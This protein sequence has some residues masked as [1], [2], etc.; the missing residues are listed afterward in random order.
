MN[1]LTEPTIDVYA[2]G[3]DSRDL[4]LPGL[5]AGLSCG[6][7]DGFPSLQPHQRH[8]WHAFLV[9]LAAIAL[10]AAGRCDPP[11]EEDAWR[12][13]LRAIASGPE[14][15]P[16]R[17]VVDDLAR[18]AFMQP[19]VPEGTLEGFG[20]PLS[21][22]SDLDVLVTSMNH[23]V[24][25]RR[26]VNARPAHWVYAL[27]TLQTMQGYSGAGKHGI[28]R[29]NGVFA[30]RPCVG[31]AP[32]DRCAE[33][34]CRDVAVLL[35]A[36]SEL[37]RAYAPAFRESGGVS[38]L[39]LEAWNGIEALTMETLDPYYIEVCRRVRLNRFGNRIWA[40]TRGTK[41]TRIAAKELNGKTGDPWTPIDRQKEE[42]LTVRKRGFDYR[43]LHRLL[44]SPDYQPGVCQEIHPGGPKEDIL[45]LTHALARGKGKTYGLHERRL[46]VPAR[47][48]RL[49]AV[50]EDRERLGRLARS[51]VED[52][53][54]L[55]GKVL[56]PA[57]LCLVQGGAESLNSKD[58]RP[59]DCME[60][61][62]REVD[63]RFFPHLWRTLDL[64]EEEGQAG[65]Q[66]T[67]V[68]LGWNILIDAQ[69]ALPVPGPRRYRA[70]AAAERVYRKA[71]WKQFPLL[72]RREEGTA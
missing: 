44:F 38:L 48:C 35:R 32:Q 19:P 62:D 53:E 70:I 14:D 39:W 29:M 66:R 26:I 20:D 45:V 43:L 50:P 46:P 4:T 55:A 65:W 64:P 6:Q 5:L 59:R 47:A 56:R 12:T 58:R 15:E 52:V 30:S 3:G 69:A 34:F 2:P 8:A 51:R 16:W 21:S 22:P 36:R 31:L 41:S 23:D 11:A 71:G 13:H 42:A 40:R 54:A 9:Q 17:L 68:D 57:L 27:I 60:R 24:K 7:V 33:R 49:L 67:I 1:L 10:H 18:P 37:L 28:S 25:P 63:E 61:L 72:R